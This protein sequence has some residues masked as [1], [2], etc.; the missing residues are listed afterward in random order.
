MGKNDTNDAVQGAALG[1]NS[2]I[3][4][5]RKI[6]WDTRFSLAIGVVLLVLFFVSMFIFVAVSNR[7]TSCAMYLNQYRIGS[8]TLTSAV[9]CYAVTG[10][11]Q[12]YDAYM[13]ELEVD[14]NRDIAWAGLKESGLSD[15]EWEQF[16]VISSLSD[17]L[18]PLEENA[19]AS[20]DAG[21]LQAAVDYVFGQ[22]Y[23][24]AVLTISA[25][26]DSVIMQIQDRLERRKDRVL[27]FQIICA[28]LFLGGFIKMA[29]QGL[30]TIGFAESELL[31]P[32][33]KVSEQM[34]ALAA[35]NLHTE[36]ALEADDSEVGKMVED[37]AAMK[38]SLVGMI[39]EIAFVLEQ[40][41]Q[42]NYQV[43]VAREY[44]GEFTQIK[45]SLEQ[46]VAEMKDT[47]SDIAIATGEIDSGAGQL[48][49]AAGDLAQA[50]TTQACQVSDVVMLISQ[51]QENINDNEKEAQEAVKISSLAGS[52][53]VA[54][55][56]K[57][58]ELDAALMK[59]GGCA[60][61]RD[62][63]EDLA[64]CVEEMQMG[65]DETAARING[66]VDNFKVEVDSISQISD[67]I[68]VIAGLVDINSAT[69]DETAAVGDELKSQVETMVGL[70]SRFRV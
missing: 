24:E 70:M 39:E 50:C 14:R 64:V 2:Q 7:Q 23:N 5:L 66:I 68:N 62:I 44:V 37:I 6:V 31:A 21:D 60:G 33:I 41:G 12:Y 43:E 15:D 13:K 11:R 36:L 19:M 28:V 30:K 52:T 9:R 55:G 27:V 65:S 34:K 45:E 22:E 18:V 38:D 42:G 67:D 40:M 17:G 58:K 54:A 20:V 4:R 69:S 10:D 49:Q 26:T 47:I 25:L 57:L 29:V 63:T 8:K 59:M 51:L 48:A 3:V 32:I 1:K 46:I 53:L 61:L 16:N 35:G 56:E